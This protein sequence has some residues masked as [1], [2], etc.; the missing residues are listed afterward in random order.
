MPIYS[1]SLGNLKWVY[2]KLQELHSI[3]YHSHAT[4]LLLGRIQNPTS[5]K[6]KLSLFDKTS[7]LNRRLRCIF[8]LTFRLYLVLNLKKKFKLGV[9]KRSPT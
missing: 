1:Y 5:P 3:V 6:I 2:F 9:R 4:D 8:I 7:K